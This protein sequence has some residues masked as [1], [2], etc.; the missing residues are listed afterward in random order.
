M[1]DYTSTIAAKQTQA[2]VKGPPAGS[3]GSESARPVHSYQ[4][5]ATPTATGCPSTVNDDTNAPV[6]PSPATP[7]SPQ[8]L[9]TTAFGFGLNEAGAA[10]SRCQTTVWPATPPAS[11][12]SPAFSR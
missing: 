11:T 8:S 12:G 4:D 10:T 7:T 9:A 6:G 1:A 3:P 5:A 2:L